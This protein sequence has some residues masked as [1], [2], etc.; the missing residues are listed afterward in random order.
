MAADRTVV[1]LKAAHHRLE[2]SVRVVVQ[3]HVHGA[4]SIFVLASL[5]VWR[6]SRTRSG[7]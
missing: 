3:W 4:F 6:F 1:I 5:Q 2:I 7:F